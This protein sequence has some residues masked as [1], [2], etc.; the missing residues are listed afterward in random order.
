MRRRAF[1]CSCPIVFIDQ[2]G[3]WRGFAGW[4]ED[5]LVR[6]GLWSGNEFNKLAFADTAEQAVALL[7]ERLSQVS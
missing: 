5:E 3:L 2:A 7:E 1:D 4:M 6:R